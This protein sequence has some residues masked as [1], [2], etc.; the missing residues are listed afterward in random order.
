[1]S[2]K[3]QLEA[4]KPS[5]VAYAPG[6]VNGSASVTGREAA[7]R[8][9]APTYDSA[10]WDS[11][12]AVYSSTSSILSTQCVRIAW[13]PVTLCRSRWKPVRGIRFSGGY[14]DTS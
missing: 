8:T 14:N 3:D 9:L 12:L 5:G 13:T 11:I 10:Y 2:G 6:R 4:R 7:E 1:M